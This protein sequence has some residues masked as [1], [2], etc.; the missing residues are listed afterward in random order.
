MGFV[1]VVF[2]PDTMNSN[3]MS[4]T[5]TTAR[6]L[7]LHATTRVADAT[8]D[9]WA[10]AEKAR[11]TDD[12]AK[13]ALETANVSGDPIDKAEANT[14]RRDARETAA[15]TLSRAK[16]AVDEIKQLAEWAEAAM[17]AAEAVMTTLN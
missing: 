3:T 9:V 13:T 2:V 8:K 12:Y 7:Y 5:E 16:I 17:R 10:A 6:E 1:G 4:L 11:E 15:W 14:A